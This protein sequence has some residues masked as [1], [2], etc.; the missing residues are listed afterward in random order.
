MVAFSHCKAH[1]DMMAANPHMFVV[2]AR[3]QLGHEGYELLMEKSRELYKGWKRDL[4][5]IAAHY[6]AE[7][8]KMEEKRA[9]GYRGRLEFQSWT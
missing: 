6:K 5:D 8:E 4:T 7:Y 1:H 3:E 2:W 9:R